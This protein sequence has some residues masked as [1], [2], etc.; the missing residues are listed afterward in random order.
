MLRVY[1]DDPHHAFA[2]DHLAF[3]TNWFYR[4]SYFHNLIILLR[5]YYGLVSTQGPFSVTA[6]QCS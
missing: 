4:R 5:A 6:T 3:G 2:V 1:A